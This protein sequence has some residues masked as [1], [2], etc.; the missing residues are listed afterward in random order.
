MEVRH[1][2]GR[3][4]TA[5][6]RYVGSCAWFVDAA[7]KRGA[8]G[9]A[10]RLDFFTFFLLRPAQPADLRR[11]V[12]SATCVYARQVKRHDANV[13]FGRWRAEARS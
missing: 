8:G 7:I 12:R 5:T 4:G 2:I 1:E 13:T 3:D 9:S 6:N 11:F 10:L